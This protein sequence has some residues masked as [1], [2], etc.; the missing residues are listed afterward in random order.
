MIRKLPWL[1]L[2]ACVASA[3]QADDKTRDEAMV[4]LASR[5]GCM[6]CHHIEADARGPEGLPPIGPA[7]RDVATKYRGQKGAEEALVHTVLTG[8]NPY[9]SHWKGKASGLAMPPN[10]VAIQEP[11]VRE[12][13]RWILALG[14]R[15][16]A[17][18]APD[19]KQPN[20]GRPAS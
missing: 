2:L 8:S 16:A 15:G 13:V 10:A 18:A 14:P 1:A 11:E 20:R 17:R 5:S 19:A 9:Q 7:W 12:L 3:A 6:A 4:Q